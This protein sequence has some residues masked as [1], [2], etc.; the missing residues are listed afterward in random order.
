VAAFVGYTQKCEYGGVSHLN[1]PL[2]VSSLA[3]FTE[4]FGGPP[5]YVKGSLVDSYM[6][7]YSVDQFFYNGGNECYVVSVGLYGQ[8]VERV[9]L[10]MGLDALV[11]GPGVSILVV[12][13]AVLLP[14]EDCFALQR[15]MLALCGCKLNGCFAVLDIHSGYN[16]RGGSDDPIVA[17][18]RGIGDD[19][20]SFGA[21][22]YPWVKRVET[23]SFLPVSGIVAG[24]YCG[25]DSAVGVWKAP[26]NVQVKHIAGL[27]FK[28][29][30]AFINGL[31]A[32]PGIK[33]VNGLLCTLFEGIRLWGSRTL[34][35]SH[36]EFKFINVVRTRLMIEDSLRLYLSPFAYE[37]NGPETWA[38][39]KSVVNDFLGELRKKGALQGSNDAFSVEVGLG[40]T[41]CDNDLHQ[42]NL[43]I[44]VNIAL[45]RPGIFHPINLSYKKRE[46]PT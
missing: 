15:E 34:D 31:N 22:Y 7:Y 2:R 37:N 33:P 4:F 23:G 38:K 32:A 11:G 41:M 30:L 1:R 28:T 43:H 6:L 14:A 27:A 5:E 13:E 42:G 9:R 16:V 10:S 39:I 3:Q 24:L 26:A 20:L 21:A 8:E 18:S 29:D 36:D 44:R 40:E 12:P 25:V 19:Y 46:F 17:F 45:T 35:S